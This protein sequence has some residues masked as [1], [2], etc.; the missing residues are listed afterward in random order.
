MATAI[1]RN[2]DWGD[3]VTV[4]SRCEFDLFTPLAEAIFGT[5][6]PMPAEA[7]FPIRTGSFTRTDGGGG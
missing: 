5:G 7:V 4:N 6:R 3:H 2:N 1:A